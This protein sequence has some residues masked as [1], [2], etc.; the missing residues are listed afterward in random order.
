[1]FTQLSIESAKAGT[2]IVFDEGFSF[3]I[4]VIPSYGLT[5]G[6]LPYPLTRFPLLLDLVT[7]ATANIHQTFMSKELVC[8][9]LLGYDRKPLKE[10]RFGQGFSRSTSGVP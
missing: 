9:G 4:P 1:M 8:V 5:L 10:I 2:E 3:G 6:D 7:I